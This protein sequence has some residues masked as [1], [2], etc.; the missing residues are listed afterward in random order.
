M[1]CLFVNIFIAYDKYSPL[2]RD[3]FTQP[4]HMK[5]SQKEE[6]F[7][8][9]FRALLKSRLNFQHFQKKLDPHT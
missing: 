8:E 6:S 3:N 5:L 1:L 4:I 9:F 2:H 7:P